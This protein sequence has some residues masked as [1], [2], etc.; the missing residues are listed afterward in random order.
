MSSTNHLPKYRVRPRFK[1]H[2]EDNA[3]AFIDLVSIQL[4]Q[5]N[6][7]CIGK[8]NASHIAL[9]IPIK[10]QHYWSPQLSITFDSV[11][12]NSGCIV[13][14]LYGPNPSI[15]TMFVFFYALIAFAILVISMIG[16]S[17]LSLGHSASILWLIPGLIILFLT[18]FL[19]AYFGQKKGEEQ[20]V[21]LHQFV[22]ECIGFPIDDARCIH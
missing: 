21:T 1:F 7:S 13:R 16:G 3:E 14:G 17:Q 12:N 6:A 4:K 22:E 18:L 5:E 10:D 2:F 8:I 11:E 20:M 9:L 19:V 15:W